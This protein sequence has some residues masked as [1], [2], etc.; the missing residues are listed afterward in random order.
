MDTVDVSIVLACYNAS[1][2][3]EESIRQIQAVMDATIY[4]YELIFVDDKSKDDTVAIVQKCIEGK[5]NCH[6]H[7][8]DINIGRGKTVFDGF[9]KAQGTIVGFIDLDLDNPARYIPSMILGIRSGNADVCTALR[10]YQWKLNLYF[11]VRLIC[12][13]GYAFLSSRLLG[14]NLKDTETGCKFFRKE[15]IMPS[16]QESKSSGWFWDTEIMTRAYYADLKILEIPTLFI[17]NTHVSTVNLLPETLRYLKSLMK[18]LPVVK[19]LRPAWLHRRE[20]SVIY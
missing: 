18:F 9:T 2:Y 1:S 7:L 11:L 12:S 4:R 8:H 10:V 3:A 13:K 19:K 16:M 5:D 20:K 17:R 6:L 14:T 15:K